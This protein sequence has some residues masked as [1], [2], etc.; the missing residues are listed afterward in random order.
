MSEIKQHFDAILRELA[1]APANAVQELLNCGDS[2]L[3][4]L[5]IATTLRPIQDFRLLEGL[6]YAQSEVQFFRRMNSAAEQKQALE[7][8]KKLSRHVICAR[9]ERIEWNPFTRRVRHGGC[10]NAC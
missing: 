4:V 5:P 6:L 9:R 2:L 8:D 7:P 3:Y 1:K 10:S